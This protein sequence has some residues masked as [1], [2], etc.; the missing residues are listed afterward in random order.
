MKPSGLKAFAAR[1]KTKSG[2]YSFENKPRQLSVA[3]ERQFKSNP[4]AWEFFRQQ[5]PG[6]RRVTSFWVMCAKRAETR[7]RRLTRLMADSARGR[8]LGLLGGGK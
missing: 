4:A 3:L 6:Y 2:V 8:R 1:T 5:P 7:Q